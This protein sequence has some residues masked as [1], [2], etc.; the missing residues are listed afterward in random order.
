MKIP[1]VQVK[2]IAVFRA[3]QLGD[4]LCSI[5]A[6]RALHAAYPDA[7][8]TLLG[9]PWAKSLTERFPAYF[10]HFI[11]FPGYPGLPE[12]VFKPVDFT[13]FLQQ[14][15]EQEF[16]LA[17][18]MQG[19]GTVVNPMVELFGAK[20]TA[21]FC[22][23]HD[24]CPDRSL[25]LEYPEGISEIERHLAL[26]NH[27]GIASQGTDLE[28]PI[29]ADEERELASLDIAL[30]KGNYVCVHP[31]SRGAWRQWPPE[32]F[33]KLADYCASQGLQVVVTGTKDEKQIVEEVIGRMS[34]K[35]YD[36]SGKTGLGAI[37]ALIRNAR[38]LVSNCT[39]V[40][41]IA[42]ACKTRSI[43]I[44]M[45]GEPE[46]WG[47]LNKSI[48][49]TIDWLKTPDYNLVFKETVALLSS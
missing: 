30:E 39:G 27:L 28:F 34:A 48:H 42:A 29:S 15:Q 3:L 16:D 12:Q 11:H 32:C 20:Y 4:M 25:F 46:R 41:H 7:K 49:R 40:S 43:V 10:N 19:N 13:K 8:I 22:V 17:L 18:Q 26:M 36:A 14:V 23:K 37:G 44:S 38:L 21:G 5:P 45:D 33:A 2:K 31:G 6:I 24:Y 35:P 9:L 1:V 47:P